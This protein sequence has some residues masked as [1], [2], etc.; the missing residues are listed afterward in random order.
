MSAPRLDDAACNW[1]PDEVTCTPMEQIAYW[2]AAAVVSC[3]TL[4][5]AV[6]VAC[7]V[8]GYLVG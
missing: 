8:Y 2:V 5:T 1:Q 6:G 7:F 3:L 4:G